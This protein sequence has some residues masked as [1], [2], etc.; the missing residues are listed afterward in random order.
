MTW[1]ER[2]GRI[3][4]LALVSAL[5]SLAGGEPGGEPTLDWPPDG[6]SLIVR[7]PRRGHAGC[8]SEVD[9]FSG[10]DWITFSP[11]SA[12]HPL[13]EGQAYCAAERHV[14]CSRIGRRP[15]A[16]LR[17]CGAP[18]SGHAVQVRRCGYRVRVVGLPGSTQRV[19]AVAGNAVTK[20]PRACATQCTAPG[21]LDT[22]LAVIMQPLRCWA[23]APGGRRPGCGGRGARRATPGCSAP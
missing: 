22:S 19:K 14:Y 8:C 4:D 17:R 3:G 16:A 2:F 20:Y 11:M 15:A 10:D 1:E 23:R 18:G 13:R 6:F 21:F 7:G 5:A 12:W 9:H